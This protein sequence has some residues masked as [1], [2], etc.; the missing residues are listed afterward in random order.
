M[1]IDYKEGNTITITQADYDSLVRD[2]ERLSLLI[3]AIVMSGTYSKAAEC[4]LFSDR[5]VSDFVRV[6]FPW[7]FE[8]IKGKTADE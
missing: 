8:R 5:L 7:T 1:C 4:I 6:L 3:D 2:S